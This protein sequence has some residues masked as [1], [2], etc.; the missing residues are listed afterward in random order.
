MTK[1][2]GGSG[3]TDGEVDGEKKDTDDSVTLDE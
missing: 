3:N 1:N 2:I